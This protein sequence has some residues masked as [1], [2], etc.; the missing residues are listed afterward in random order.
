MLTP[1]LLKVI[2]EFCPREASLVASSIL[3][4]LSERTLFCKYFPQWLSHF[5]CF[6]HYLFC[7]CVAPRSSLFW[8]H[9]TSIQSLW[10]IVWFGFQNSRHKPRGGNWEVSWGL[11]GQLIGFG[12]CRKRFSQVIFTQNDDTVAA[13]LYAVGK[14]FLTVLVP[15]ELRNEEAVNTISALLNVVSDPESLD[16]V[17]G[18]LKSANQLKGL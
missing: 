10:G 2:K 5:R 12:V 1:T 17:L 7:G 8:Q 16:L 13:T 14:T 11:E 4:E 15:D 6:S 18:L 9:Q 3:L